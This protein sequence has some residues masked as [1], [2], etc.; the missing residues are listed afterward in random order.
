YNFDKVAGDLLMTQD[1]K[2]Y[3]DIDRANVK[4]FALKGPNGGYVFERVPLLDP[5][6]YFE[7][8]GK[9]QR[10]AAYKAIKTKFVKANGQANGLTSVGNDYD[11]YVDQFDYFFIDLKTKEVRRFE[12]KKKSIRDAVGDARDRADKYMA[13]HKRDE[14]DDKFVNGLVNF[15]NS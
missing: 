12:L 10:Y 9:G 5:S 4:S 15:L 13:D 7:V 3:I 2:T 6:T 11:E 8:L 1:R 14:I